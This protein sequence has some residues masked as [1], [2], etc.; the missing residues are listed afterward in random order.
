MPRISGAPPIRESRPICGGVFSVVVEMSQEHFYQ[1]VSSFD[2]P[3]L[4]DMG[5]P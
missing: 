3:A 4:G 2:P 5:T 1:F